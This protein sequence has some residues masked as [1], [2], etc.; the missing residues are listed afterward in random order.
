VEWKKGRWALTIWYTWTEKA[1]S[2]IHLLFL[3]N[4]N[5]DFEI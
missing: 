2:L 4:N 5:K 3:N 1:I